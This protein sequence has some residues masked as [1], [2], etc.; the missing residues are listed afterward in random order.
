MQYRGKG[1]SP[2]GDKNRVVLPA[3][4][5]DTVKAASRG[6]RTLCMQHHY[7]LPCLMAFG[8]DRADQADAEAEVAYGRAERENRPFNFTVFTSLVSSADDLTFDDSGR[9]VLPRQFITPAAQAEG[10]FFHSN[11][12]EILIWVPSI[13]EAQGPE[14]DPFKAACRAH[15]EDFAAKEKR[16]PKR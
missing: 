12:P 15:V 10:L 1:F 9:F 14:W 16:G 8:T 5:R 11:G 4:F 7:Y 13:L 3:S 2:I 6:S